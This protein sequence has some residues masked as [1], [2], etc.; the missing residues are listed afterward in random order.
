MSYY[1]EIKDLT[2]MEYVGYL[3]NKYD[4]VKM[5]YY[6][7][8]Y[9]RSKDTFARENN[10]NVHHIYIA[11]GLELWRREVAMANSYELQL[12]SNLVYCTD[13]EKAYLNVLY[14][15][16][17]LTNGYAV[18]YKKQP[19]IHWGT[20]KLLSMEKD[21][22]EEELEF[23][24]CSYIRE[25]AFAKEI[26]A[27]V[28]G[29]NPNY[30][31]KE[32]VLRSESVFSTSEELAKGQYESFYDFIHAHCRDKDALFKLNISIDIA[33]YYFTHKR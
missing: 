21:W 27:G 3:I 14:C 29:V 15:E 33:E 23:L 2:Y 1:S 18:L 6:T 20:I 4:I 17:C 22:T 5:P 7:K 13:I 16:A 31:H 9:F 10:L 12:P 19:K 8:G 26:K 11:D 30:T 24:I 32:R 28:F 25:V